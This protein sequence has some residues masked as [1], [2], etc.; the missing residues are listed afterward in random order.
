MTTSADKVDQ[1]LNS[2][3]MAAELTI[4]LDASLNG[5]VPKSQMAAREAARLQARETTMRETI[6]AHLKKRDIISD[7]AAYM[8]LVQILQSTGEAFVNQVEKAR[9]VTS[10]LSGEISAVNDWNKHIGHQLHQSHSKK[11]FVP[12]TNTAENLAQFAAPSTTWYALEGGN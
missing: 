3:K 12:P 7:S 6:E 4:D 10:S 5:Y 1:V 2:A 11:P 8:T 9:H